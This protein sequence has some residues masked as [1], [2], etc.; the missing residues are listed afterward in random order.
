MR[1]NR[2]SCTLLLLQKSMSSSSSGD[3]E[4]PLNKYLYLFYDIVRCKLSADTLM[5]F[6]DDIGKQILTLL[7]IGVLL[8]HGNICCYYCH[9]YCDCYSC[10]FATAT[11]IVVVVGMTI[12]FN[13]KYI[14]SYY[15]V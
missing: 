8:V 3:V 5:M 13:Y 2:T 1:M 4:V 7:I 6:Y 9:C 14:Y 15:N 11:T 12:Q 10:Y